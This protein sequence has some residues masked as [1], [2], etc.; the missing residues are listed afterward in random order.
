MQGVKRRWDILEYI[1]TGILILD[2]DGA[3]VYVNQE[4]CDTVEKP[5]RFFAGMTIPKL[6]EMGWI[7]TSVW[8]QVLASR[9]P[10]VA[11]ISIT[12]GK[13]P[14]FNA[15]TIGTPVFDQDGEIQ[16]VVVRQEALTSLSKRM[17][18]ASHN[19]LQFSEGAPI[20][21]LPGKKLIAESPKMKEIIRT[22]STVSNTE[23]SVL[24]SGGSGTGKE[25]LANYIHYNS[26]RSRGPLITINCAAIPENLLETEL[27]GYVEGAFTGASRGGKAGLIESADGGTLFLDEINSIPLSTQGKLLRV[28][29]TKQV[30]RV[31]SVTSKKIDFRLICASNED[32]LTLVAEKKFRIDLFYRIN[33]VSFSIP[34]LAQ[35][36][37]DILPL[38]MFFLET[39][40]KKY[41]RAKVLSETAIQQIL[42]Y[43]WPGNVREL[44]NAVE[45]AVVVSPEF[46]LQQLDLP[47]TTQQTQEISSA[48]EPAPAPTL[49]F[50]Y[51]HMHL[52]SYLDMCEEHLLRTLIDDGYSAVQIA[53]QL[54]IDRSSVFR[55]LNKYHLKVK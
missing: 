38:A 27:F 32:L 37:E 41:G 18:N 42:A 2:R 19:H 44:R 31:G 51:N 49:L 15:L 45:R 14:P 35:R 50:P 55:K 23:V 11:I 30:A 20:T 33:V 39:F 3:Y 13:V 52:N 54:G 53:Q 26:M 24:I 17:E 21:A 7:Q 22:L 4:Y 46:E 43:H 48:A 34:P 10:T 29:E 12:T 8:E 1:S 25:V 28:L 5:R 9:Q 16:Y 47:S 6:K 40:C 36:K